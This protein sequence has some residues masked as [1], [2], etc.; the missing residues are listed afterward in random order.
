MDQLALNQTRKAKAKGKSKSKGKKK[1]S[2]EEERPKDEEG[3]EDQAGAPEEGGAADN[4]GAEE[5]ALEDQEENGQAREKK[6]ETQT[7]GPRWWGEEEAVGPF[8]HTS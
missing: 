4:E 6:K 7:Q 2:N 8:L 1:K 5:Q 3:A